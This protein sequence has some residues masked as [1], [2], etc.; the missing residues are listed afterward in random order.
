MNNQEAQLILR[1][2]RPGGEDAS[3]P[4]MAAALEQAQRDPALQKWI[5]QEQAV[6]AAIQGKLRAAIAIPPELKGNLLALQKIARGKTRWRQPIWLAAAACVA[7]LLGAAGLWLRPGS[8]SRLD[9]F[10]EAMVRYS[11]DQ[12]DHVAFESADLTKIGQW[13]RDRTMNAEFELPGGL[14]GQAAKG[15]RLVD[16]R[17]RKVALICFVLSDGRHVDFFVMDR[18]GLPGLVEG[19]KP[20]FARTGTLMTA[21]WSEG[22]RVYLLTATGN[23][24]ILGQIL[25]TSV[26]RQGARPKILARRGYR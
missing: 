12:H 18:A 6:D 9:S 11:M 1:A 8:S 15:C 17:G 13:L 16:W 3:D 24:K 4:A 7:L 10:R 5:A 23:G 20:Q 2:Y 14:R 22:D 21:T 19:G 26:S 25:R